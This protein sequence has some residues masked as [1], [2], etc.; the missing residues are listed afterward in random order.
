MLRVHIIT[1]LELQTFIKKVNGFGSIPK[2]LL[3]LSF[4]IQMNLVV[5]LKAIV[6]C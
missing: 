2:S 1:G 3:V 5:E 4:G 6:C